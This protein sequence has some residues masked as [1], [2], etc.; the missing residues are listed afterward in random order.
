MKKFVI[1]LP[2]NPSFQDVVQFLK[3]TKIVV[4]E[5]YPGL[6]DLQRVHPDWVSEE[7]S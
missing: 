2:E 1:R 3:F 5:N 6:V 7:K 4:V